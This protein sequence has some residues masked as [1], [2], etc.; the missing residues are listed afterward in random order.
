MSNEQHLTQALPL[1]RERTHSTKIVPV[2][3]VPQSHI[4]TRQNTKKN[5]N[6]ARSDQE[7][8][9]SG[10]NYFQSYRSIK[11]N[12]IPPLGKGARSKL[13]YLVALINEQKLIVVI[14]AG[15]LLV[16]RAQALELERFPVAAPQ[17][18]HD[19]VESD[20]RQKR[21]M[22]RLVAELALARHYR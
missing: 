22:G 4:G 19:P 18:R 21:R 16:Q 15:V 3:I 10:G 12:P 7:Q 1:N 2:P 13:P 6:K 14:A 5:T 11:A 17:Q 20:F 8:E 9:H